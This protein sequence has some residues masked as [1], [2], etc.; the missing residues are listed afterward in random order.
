MNLAEAYAGLGRKEDS[1]A[2][3]KKALELR[4]ESLDALIGPNLANDLAFIYAWLGEPEEA[5]KQLEHLLIVPSFTTV[6][7]LKFSPNW[8]P[9][10]GH[11]RFHALITK[12]EA[13]IDQ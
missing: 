8:D 12:Y 1:L 3:A 6:T 9:L 5:L 10:R 7:D 13:K 2:T 11:P 4:P